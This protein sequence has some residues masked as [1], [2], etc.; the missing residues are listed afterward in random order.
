MKQLTFL[1]LVLLLPS[2]SVEDD[3]APLFIEPIYVNNPT[4]KL[5]L[6]IIYVLPNEKYA[7]SKYNIDESKYL[8]YLNGCFFNRHDIGIVLGESRTLVNPELY[9]L[10]DDRGNESAIFERE[11]KGTCKPDRLNMYIIPRT[12][13]IAIAGLGV[14]QRT[15]ITDEFLFKTTSPHEIGH[16]LGLHHLDVDGNIMSRVKPYLR[17]EFNSEQVS[18]L[19]QQI[20]TINNR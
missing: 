9:D 13:T 17:K 10:K 5:K 11:T 3:S 2:C 8:D 18:E 6:D 12:N 15:L 20:I 14:T 16:S 1:L 4:F 7:K 19:I